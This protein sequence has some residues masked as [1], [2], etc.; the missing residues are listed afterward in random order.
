MSRSRRPAK[1]GGEKRCRCY[2]CDPFARLGDYRERRTM[3]DREAIA[4]SATGYLHPA[5]IRLIEHDA[6]ACQV[7]PGE[8]D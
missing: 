2:L 7:C 3:P 8:V 1:T 6:G 5:E 4:D